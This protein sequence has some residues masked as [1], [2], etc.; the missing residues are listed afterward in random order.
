M[1]RQ[2]YDRFWARLAQ[3]GES[4]TRRSQRVLGTTI[5][6]IASI[7]TAVNALRYAA[8]GLGEVGQVYAVMAAGLA[9]ALALGIAFPQRF[10]TIAFVVILFSI[11]CTVVAHNLIGGYASGLQIIQWTIINLVFAVLF[12]S[13]RYVLLTVAYF[14]LLVAVS[15]LRQ[16]QIES[17]APGL[18]PGFVGNDATVNIVLMGLLI[19]GSGLYLFNQI[20]RYRRKADNLLLNIL[21]GSIAER[22]KEDPSTIAD[23]FKEVTV[24]FADIVDFT[25]LSA[26]ANAVDVVCKL[27]EIFSE[28]DLLAARHGLE[29]IKTIGDAYMVAGG[30]PQPRNDHCAAVAAFALD[31]VAEM[32]RHKAWDGRPLRIRV[33]INTGPVVA[34]VIGR[35]K[36]IYDLWGDAVNVASRMESNG[37]SNQIQVTQAVRDEL[38]GRYEFEARGPI[39]VKGK[40][41]MTTYLLLDKRAARSPAVASPGGA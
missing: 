35:Q 37:L 18:S 28:F 27:N 31:I 22:L 34:G 39:A 21:P 40:G 9:A 4:E 13:R 36:F 19:T 16:P 38:A 3:P 5:L 7:S 30:L 32:D 6:L 14:I 20:E 8:I 33:G 25:A 29:K 11:T 10:E 23:G 17:L 26:E 2:Y 41:Q 1:V 15:G 24:L 12:T